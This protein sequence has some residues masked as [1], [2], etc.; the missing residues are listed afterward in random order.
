[1]LESVLVVPSQIGGGGWDGVLKVGIY[2]IVIM[3]TVT[4]THLKCA[5][6]VL[7]MR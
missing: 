1:M 5:E 3:Y 4:C 7:S 6:Y 2:V